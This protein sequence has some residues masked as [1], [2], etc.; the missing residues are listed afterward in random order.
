MEQD[1]KVAVEG[2]G[3]RRDGW[4]GWVDAAGG[5]VLLTSCPVDAA[6]VAWSLVEP[7]LATP[8]THQ[9]IHAHSLLRRSRMARA[10]CVSG[11]APALDEGFPLYA[12]VR[13]I[14]SGTVS[15]LVRMSATQSATKAWLDARQGFSRR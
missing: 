14:G 7:S 6:V 8:G 12:R 11:E 1:S 13:R 2:V 4:M 9:A 10:R 3:G 15:P 5:C